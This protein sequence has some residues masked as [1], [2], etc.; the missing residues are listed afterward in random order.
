M[1]GEKIRE[2]R[3][4]R[5]IS[6]SELAERVGVSDSYISQ[7][8]RN[9]VD[10]SI[11]VLKKISQ[12]LDVAIA[13][14]FDEKYEEPAIIQRDERI[15]HPD[16]TSDMLLELL[17]PQPG[18]WENHIEAASYKIPPKKTIKDLKY[19]GETCIHVLKGSME[20][21]IGDMS[22]LLRK[23]DSIYLWANVVFQIYNPGTNA[24]SGII[25]STGVLEKEQAL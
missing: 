6:L 7:L 3:K 4:N 2:L 14:F 23:G 5:N 20:V 11:S 19:T 17:S 9:I 18:A 12:V 22:H 13:S 10:P 21:L 8:E 15:A 1:I 24:V 16:S 25:C